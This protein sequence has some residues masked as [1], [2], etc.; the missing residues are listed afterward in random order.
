MSGTPSS[1]RVE[2]ID[3]LRGL[4]MIIMVLDH[5]RD[6][7]TGMGSDPTDPARTHFALFFT[8]W[9]THFCAPVFILLA[10]T[11]IFLAGSSKISRPEL[12]RW[13]ITRGL[14]LVILEE[15]VV[16]FGLLFNPGWGWYLG[17]VFWSIGWS[18]VVLAAV[19][20]LPSRVVGAIGVAIIATHN[21]ADRFQASDFGSLGPLWH[22]LHQPGMIPFARGQVFFVMYPLIPWVG[23]MMAG[24][25]L[26]EVF[27]W[28]SRKRRTMLM[29]LGVAITLAYVALRWSNLYGDPRPWSY[30]QNNERT[31]FSFLNA[32]KYPPSLIFL[33]MTLGPALV[34]L[35]L[36]EATRPP[37][38]LR[39][40]LLT[41][42]R[43]PLFFYLLQWY[44]IHGLAVLVAAV[45]G[46]PL[47]WL[48]PP[49]MPVLAP[50]IASYG[51]SF[52]YLMWGVVLALM[53]PAC[54]WYARLKQRRRD[55]WWLSYL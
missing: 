29:S 40:P 10:G 50:K 36:L 52:V 3:L 25:A 55:L 13:L 22:V 23:V 24:Y 51:L 44:V 49:T 9:V 41:I 12:R 48:F 17:I 39:V 47:D 6:Y 30:V 38:F 1:S 28:E 54:T 46:Q 4:V 43:V 27:H 32:S 42:G 21:L 34:I 26:G 18:M 16:K 37:G 19:I 31:L 15:T 11:G 20:G 7:F 14:W 35:G 33:L 8:R 53:Y 45:R 5:T 2:S